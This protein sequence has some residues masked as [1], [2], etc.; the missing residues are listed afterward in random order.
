MLLL[1]LIAPSRTAMQMMLK[2]CEDFG[3]RNNLLFST[4]PDPSKSKTKCLFMCGR[5]RLNRPAPLSLY[6]RDLP[7]VS[8][9]SHLGNVLCQ[10]GSMEMDVREKTAGFITRSLLVREQFSFAHPMEVL[11][12]VRVYCC[13][14]YGSMLWDM[15]GD[16]AKKYFNS[17]KT[18][19]KLAWGVPRATH[20]YFL[21]YL[22]GGLVTVR[23][24]ILTRYVNF[25][26]SLL[27]SP[28]REVNILSRV[29]A[30]DIRSTTAR[31]LQL[32][33]IE[34]AG[35]TWAAPPNKVREALAIR[36]PVV[37]EVDAW[38]IKYLGSL[39][40]QRDRLVYQGEEESED[41]GRIQELINSL[42]TN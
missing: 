32:L 42:C 4:D 27:S 20:S 19:I 34:T 26:R 5:K 6:G 13:D 11:R 24:D 21:D 22:S 9:A 2:A 8:T 7:F 35:L 15:Q 29:V 30:K 3:S 38:R 37:P 23:R 39:L 16:S 41:V 1:V 28:C 40:E 36:E 31:N 10:D 18:C 25:Y 17:W 14:H 12:A 33:E